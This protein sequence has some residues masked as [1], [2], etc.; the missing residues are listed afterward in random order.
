[1]IKFAKSTS[2]CDFLPFPLRVGSKI[3]QSSWAILSYD[4]SKW[5]KGPKIV[6][7]P[8]RKVNLITPWSEKPCL[9]DVTSSDYNNRLK[10]DWVSINLGLRP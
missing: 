7:E 8:K 9:F 1:M 3:N 4:F 10:E 6:S 5:R 2:F